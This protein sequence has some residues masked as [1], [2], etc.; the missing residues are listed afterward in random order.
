MFH[1]PSLLGDDWHGW[2]VAVGL[3]KVMW[4]CMGWAGEKGSS[5]S[6]R[7]VNSPER[8]IVT[9]VHIQT[10]GQTLWAPT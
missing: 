4:T 1:C 7:R 10:D 6:L 5:A 9:L 8:S 3:E 2:A